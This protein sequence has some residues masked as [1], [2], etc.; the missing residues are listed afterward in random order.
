L[1]ITFDVERLV[2]FATDVLVLE[3]VPEGDAHTC[4]IRL[5][6]GDSRGQR[7]HGIARLPAYVRRI[8]EGGLNPTAR[9]RLERDSTVTAL[10][11]GDNGLGP[12]VM[13]YATGIAIT[14]AQE[15]GLAWI[16]V[17]HSNHA[18][19]SG[20]YV[21][22]VVDEN[23]IGI[24]AAVANSNQM[25]PWGGTDR[26]LGP[27]PIAIGVPGGEH[28]G[29]VLDMASSTVAFGVVKQTAAAGKPLPAGWLID[30]AGQSVTDP[31]SIGDATLAP[32]GGYKGYG[33]SLAIAALAGSMNG[34]RWGTHLI[35]HFEDWT[36]PT[37]TGQLIIAVDPARFRPKAD[38][39]QDIDAHLQEI[40]SSSPMEGFDSV[41]VPGDRSAER[42]HRAAEVGVE[43]GGP[44]LKE[45]QQLA[46]QIGMTDQLEN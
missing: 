28:A 4:S 38:F 7:A 5:L 19:A 35:D 39:N 36:T 32:I 2:Q 23:L 10:V 42:R 12:V 44:V 37:N 46:R 33:L 21:Q 40:R 26:L 8:E 24:Y 6:E 1:P 18:G 31:A 29:M 30:R 17:H 20:V 14:K 41:A 15:H 43:L 34:G 16:G 3:G 22:L 9:P 27:N 13:T 45:L 25:A 11:D